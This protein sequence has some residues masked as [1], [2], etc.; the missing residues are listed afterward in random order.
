MATTLRPRT[1][2]TIK[3]KTS[4]FDQYGRAEHTEKRRITK[5]AIIHLY[6]ETSKTSVRADSS[7]SRGRAD[8]RTADVRIL[9]KP[10]EEI[11]TGD[12]VSIKLKGGLDITMEVNRIFRRPDVEG[13]IHHI[14]IEGDIWVSE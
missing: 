13:S 11:A 2:C 5:C 6:N 9:L 4:K 14:D 3:R 12:L 8:E 7:A 10:T 1:P